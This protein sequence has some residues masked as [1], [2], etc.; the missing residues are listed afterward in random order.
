M[1]E[2]QHIASIDVHI[3]GGGSATIVMIHGWPDTYR[4]WDAQV[5]QLKAN[6]RC[7]RFT[8]PGFDTAKPRRAFSLAELV[9]AFKRV[10]ETT[11]PG[12][13][14]TL[15]LHD[16]GCI[17]C[18]EFAMRHPGLV[19]RIVGVDIGDAGSPAH[20]LA[21][22]AK[23]NFMVFAY[24]VWLAIAWRI[25]G[26]LGDRMTR[27]MARTMHCRSDPQFIGS[28]MNYPY[29]IQWTGAHGSYR[30][31]LRFDPHCPML[32]IWGRKKP[33]QFHS[34]EWVQAMRQRPGSQALEF[35]TGHWVM[36]AK[37]REFNDAVAVWLAAPA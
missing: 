17:F 16:W 2:P 32:Y 6:Y 26:T 4:L 21:M 37:P 35:N 5:E 25:G 30:H 7:I 29:Y 34:T 15:L 22:S 11:C 23:A 27:W 36:T 9:E 10:I 18:Y 14:V 33:F 13:R 1:S 28:A 24:Q 3:E 8:L 12:E 20:R 19:R 31:A